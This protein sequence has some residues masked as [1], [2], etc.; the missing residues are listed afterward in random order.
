MVAKWAKI[1]LQMGGNRPPNG[2]KLAAKWAEIG[3]QMGNSLI[4]LYKLNFQFF[5][6]S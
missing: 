6:L 5:N 1:G 3:R 2:Q 4:K